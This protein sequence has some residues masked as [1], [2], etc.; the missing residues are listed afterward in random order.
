M[1]GRKFVLYFSAI[2]KRKF[3]RA[4]ALGGPIPHVL[5]DGRKPLFPRCFR[6]E[7]KKARRWRRA[8]SSSS[9]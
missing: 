2:G 4:P 7:M 1:P 9:V 3:S 5:D 8:F 6:R